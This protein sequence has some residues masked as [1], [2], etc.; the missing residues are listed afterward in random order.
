MH[1]IVLCAGT[2]A[3]IKSVYAG[4]KLLLPVAGKTLLERMLYGFKRSRIDACQLVFVVGWEHETLRRHLPMG[5]SVIVNDR[6]AQTNTVG[7]LSL[8]LKQFDGDVMILNGDVAADPECYAS[9]ASAQQ[10]CALVDLKPTGAEEVKYYLTPREHL[11][12]VGK[13][14][15]P[16]IAFGEV[17]GINK[18]VSADRPA[19]DAA[20]AQLAETTFYDRAFSDIP[21]YPVFLLGRRCVEID[22]PEDWQRAN[23]LFAE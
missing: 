19:F 18:V 2:G 20:L 8:A 1:V 13:E 5:S 21:M 23:Q 4:H 6:W 16:K 15:D 14:L 10:S 9:V 11:H 12:G 17:L 7:S 22:F 3:R